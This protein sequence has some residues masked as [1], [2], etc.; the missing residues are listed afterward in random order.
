MVWR[1]VLVCMVLLVL[2]GLFTEAQNL[3]W[4][5][6]PLRPPV[7]NFDVTCFMGT[8]YEVYRSR[9]LLDFT[10]RCGR[11]IFAQ[12]DTEDPIL[13]RYTYRPTKLFDSETTVTATMVQVDPGVDDGVFSAIYHPALAIQIEINF[14]V[15]EIGDT[16]FAI[17][18]SC[19]NYGFLRKEIIWILSRSR[20]PTDGEMDDINAAIAA[21]NIDI[22]KLVRTDGGCPPEDVEIPCL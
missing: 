12:E 16:D 10:N 19:Q 6:C 7:E 8:W 2:S 11:I 17:L 3:R 22:D 5:L 20:P 13:I 21:Q 4:G 15:V 9:G 1:H 14:S 18:V